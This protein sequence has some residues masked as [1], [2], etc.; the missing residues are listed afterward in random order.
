LRPVE[1]GLLGQLN[2]IGPVLF[3]SVAV[4]QVWATV[5]TGCSPQLPFWE[6]KNRTELD[7][8]TLDADQHTG[9]YDYLQANKDSTWTAHQDAY[10][11]PFILVVDRSGMHLLPVIW[12]QCHQ[13]VG[14][15][16][17]ALDLQLYPASGGLI[18]TVFTF[19][20]LDDF[21]AESQE[22]N[23]SHYHYVAK[24]WRFTNPIFPDIVPVC[25]P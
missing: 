13:H 7:L 10:G 3:S 15:E 23:T 8:K 6:S 20:S 4:L 14:H 12:H 11:H 16:W 25:K 17:Q 1:T 5:W 19:E 22:C 21:L 24:L 9:D 18:R 2:R